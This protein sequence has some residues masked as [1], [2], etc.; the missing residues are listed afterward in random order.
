MRKRIFKLIVAVE[1]LDRTVRPPVMQETTLVYE[2]G[3]DLP[4]IP[5]EPDDHLKVVHIRYDEQFEDDGTPNG[6]YEVLLAPDQGTDLHASG[7]GI[8]IEHS[9]TEV[10]R[11]YEGVPLQDMKKVLDDFEE[12]YT[13]PDEASAQEEE[14][15]DDVHDT[16][17]E[18][19][20]AHQA[21]ATGQPTGSA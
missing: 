2:L 11:V 9:V 17:P 15:E 7:I 8:V 20:Q 16:K 6:I 12:E 10:R 1:S 13:K 3:K 19:T 5:G 14:E 21:G 4:R 18:A